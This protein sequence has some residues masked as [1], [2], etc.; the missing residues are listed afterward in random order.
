MPKE[1]CRVCQER[2]GCT[3]ICN[4]LELH[5]KKDI[6]IEGKEL[7]LSPD[8][9]DEEF[10]ESKSLKNLASP[11]LNEIIIKMYFKERMSQAKIA[12]KLRCHHSYVTQCVQKYLRLLNQKKGIKS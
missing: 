4:E 1:F 3:K 6:E 2:A 12:K 9:I 10:D 11:P 5:L 8:Y 7:L